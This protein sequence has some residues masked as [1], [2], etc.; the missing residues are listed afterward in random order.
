MKTLVLRAALAAVLAA[1]T[2]T[3][4]A[5]DIQVIVTDGPAVGFNDPTPAAPVGGN[6]GTTIGSQRRSECK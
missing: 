1:G 2:L 4:E 6:T 5:A 3:L